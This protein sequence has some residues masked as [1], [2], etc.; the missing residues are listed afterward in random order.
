MQRELRTFRHFHLW[1][2]FLFTVGAGLICTVF[3][4]ELL[5]TPE[6]TVSELTAQMTEHLSASAELLESNPDSVNTIFSDVVLPNFDFHTLTADTLAAY[7]ADLS[8]PERNCISSGF[9]ALFAARYA[10]FLLDYDYTRIETIPVNNSPDQ[11]IVY[12][13][14]VVMMQNPKPLSIKYKL[15]LFND[16][17]RIID[18]IID[19]VSFVKSY[20]MSFSDDIAK[21]GIGD[22]L[23][24]FPQ[25]KN[26]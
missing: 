3:A 2:F 26:R 19:N 24:S 21:V 11:K 7:W 1:L 14:Q 12:V 25:C 5:G 22:F 20:E 6:H 16:Q 23:R 10:R 17:W 13:T 15:K 9:R 18:L 8:N 4:A